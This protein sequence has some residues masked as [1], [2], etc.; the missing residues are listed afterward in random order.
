MLKAFHIKLAYVY[1]RY[2][3]NTMTG[4]D[5]SDLFL[6]LKQ[7]REYI[8]SVLKLQELSYFA[9]ETD[10]REWQHEICKRMDRLTHDPNAITA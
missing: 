8:H 4:Q 3:N 2:Q 5:Y 10:D 1:D 6:L 7:N 9:S